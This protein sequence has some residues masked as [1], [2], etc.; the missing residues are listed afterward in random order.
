MLFL[1]TMFKKNQIDVLL[2]ELIVI[3]IVQLTCGFNAGFIFNLVFNKT[4]YRFNE[5][6]HSIHT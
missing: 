3:V 1:T 6:L 2:S 4:E 5:N